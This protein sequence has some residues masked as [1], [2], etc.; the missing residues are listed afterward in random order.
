MH[1]ATISWVHECISPS[2]SRRPWFCS[3]S[4]FLW[5]L[6]CCHLSSGQYPQT[7]RKGSGM[8]TS[9]Y[10]LSVTR[11]LNFLH[12]LW[13]LLSVFFPYP[14][15]VNFSEDI[16]AKYW[17][18]SVA[19]HHQRSFRCYV[20]L[21]EGITWLF[22]RRNMLFYPRFLAYLVS[23]SRPSKKFWLCSIL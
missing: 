7:W 10:G 12:V 4:L 2:V 14:A 1:S 20:L 13:P 17:H 8:E 11:S 15:G 6:Q 5:I 16:Y 3:V 22:S 21:V 19:E 23:G 9:L 18:L